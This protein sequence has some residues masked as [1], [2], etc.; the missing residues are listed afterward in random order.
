MKFILFQSL[1]LIIA[2]IIC[3]QN[4]H[5]DLQ[6]SL[7]S[8]KLASNDSAII[9]IKIKSKFKSIV[10]IP[11]KPLYSDYSSAEGHIRFKVDKK[12]GNLYKTLDVM[13]D[14]FFPD[15][16]KNLRPLKYNDTAIFRFDLDRFYTFRPGEYRMKVFLSYLNK[17]K[18]KSSESNWFYFT[19][20]E[21]T[22][23]PKK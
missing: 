13:T 8:N 17:K 5:V 20:I 2:Q 18:A 14:I 7:E 1:F 16:K 12:E 23:K 10:Y 19:V 15:L 22:E 6:C 9:K 11:A 3:A 4:Q 21:P